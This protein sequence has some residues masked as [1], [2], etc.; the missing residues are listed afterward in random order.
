MLRRTYKLWWAILVLAVAS[1]GTLAAPATSSATIIGTPVCPAIYPRPAYCDGPAPVQLAGV[2]HVG[3]VY[4]NLNHCPQAMMCAAIY[5][6]SMPAWSW[7]GSSWRQSTLRQGWVYVYPYTGSWRW[8]WTQ[9]SGW[10]AVSSGRFEIRR[11]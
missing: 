1:A 7:T 3:W 4:L 6:D 10:V 5:R 8:A 2:R 9:Q 11:Y